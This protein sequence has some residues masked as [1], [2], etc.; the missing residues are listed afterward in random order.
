MPP[1]R[2]SVS[3]TET[4]EAEATLET[5]I[6]HPD[7]STSRGASF[8]FGLKAFEQQLF[9]RP[10]DFANFAN[11]EFVGVNSS[12]VS[13]FNS[14]KDNGD[15]F[16]P[17]FSLNSVSTNVKLGTL[18]PGDTVSYVYQLTAEGTT[19]GGEHGFVA[20][21]GDPFGADVISGNLVPTIEALPT[22]GVPEPSTWAMM[23]LGFAGLA[24][25]GWRRAA[26][27][28]AALA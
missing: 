19:H 4:A 24:F 6:I 14:F 11:F 15:Q 2:D 16:N 9:I 5:T 12:T 8:E 25:A 27:R 23:V 13:L 10:G 21:L 1:N 18:E 22:A 17:R 3:A 20:F 26:K 28:G 7:S